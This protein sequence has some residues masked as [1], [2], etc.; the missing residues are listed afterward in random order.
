[1]ATIADGPSD[2]AGQIAGRTAGRYSVI[3]NVTESI[4]C[5]FFQSTLEI[6]EVDPG[7]QA[8]RTGVGMGIH[9][10]GGVT[11]PAITKQLEIY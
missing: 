9:M 5:S 10:E 2:S 11:W 1:M 4:G 3:V 6:A 7:G 8:E